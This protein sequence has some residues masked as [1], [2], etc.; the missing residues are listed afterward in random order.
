VVAK[1][2]GLLTPNACVVVVS[3]GTHDPKQGSSIPV[4][5]FV[6][7]EYLAQ[8]ERDATHAFEQGDKLRVVMQRRYGTSKL[9]NLYLVY[10]LNRRIGDGRATIP[11]SVTVNA[12]D[13]GLMPGTGLA[14][15]CPP[16][17]R[18]IWNCVLPTVRPLLRLMMGDNV[19]S[20]Q[21]SG[22][23]LADLAA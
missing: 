12:F 16:V 2:A 18:F 14:R 20:P 10:E 7:P 6:D 4:P 5:G 17:L 11:S 1:V 15:A 9:C 3:S 19:N 13:P 8:P 22:Q 21:A 23:I